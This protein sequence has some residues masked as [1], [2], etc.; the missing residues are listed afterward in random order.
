[1]ITCNL[2]LSLGVLYM[3]ATTED[4]AALDHEQHKQH[5]RLVGKIQWLAYTTRHQLWSK[6]TSKIIKSTNTT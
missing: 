6:R 1:M 3:K 2:A 4:K 5:R